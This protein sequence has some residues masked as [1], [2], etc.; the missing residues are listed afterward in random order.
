MQL[1][2]IK[3]HEGKIYYSYLLLI[4][5]LLT[6]LFFTLLNIT[7]FKTSK[8]RIER[9]M[10]ASVFSGII[11]DYE[12]TIET[13]AEKDSIIGE[14]IEYDLQKMLEEG[15][16]IIDIEKSKDAISGYFY[17]NSSYLNDVESNIEI[18]NIEIY[19]FD[20]SQKE[21]VTPNGVTID[22]SS[23]YMKVDYNVK[24]IWGRNI[25]VSIE[26]CV[27]IRFANKE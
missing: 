8:E 22:K 19:N 25:R 4:I 17:E 10:V 23:V 14:K 13:I 7:I 24:N 16:V 3:R 26:K 9:I 15:D 12:Q 6:L 1:H 21:L 2:Y 18:A 27:A 11:L 20:D 5:S